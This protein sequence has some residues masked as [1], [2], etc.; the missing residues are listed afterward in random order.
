MVRVAVWNDKGKRRE[1]P[2]F[3]EGDFRQYVKKDSY[4]VYFLLRNPETHECMMSPLYNF[5]RPI[6]MKDNN[7][8]FEMGFIGENWEY[9]DDEKKVYKQRWDITFG[10]ED[11]GEDDI[12]IAETVSVAS[13]TRLY[14]DDDLKL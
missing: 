8:S 7:G 1:E 5:G 2:V 13:T 3:Y 6:F 11:R 14:S 10:Q 9:E 4:A 12:K